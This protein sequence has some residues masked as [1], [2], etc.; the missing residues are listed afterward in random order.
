[1][2]K[3]IAK[4]L[5]KIIGS[6]LNVL[7]HIA[8]KH[9][10]KKALDL[11]ST[12]RNGKIQENQKTFLNTAQQAE[13]HYENIPIKTYHWKGNSK[14][15]LLVHGWESNA[16]RWYKLIETLQGEG[17]NIVALDAPAHGD[18]G[19]K[20]FNALLYSKFINEIAKHHQPDIIIGHSVGGMASAFF[21]KT[22]DYNHLKKLILLGAPSEFTNIFSGYTNMM[23]FNSKLRKSIYKLIINRFGNTPESFSTAKYLKEVSVEGLIIHDK[24]DKIISHSEA[25]MI[26]ESFKNSKLISTVGF[27]HSLHHDSVNQ[28][29]LEFINS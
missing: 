26:H 8:P 27:G 13:L 15:I 20:Q 22:S 11:F 17:Y 1:M 6:S 3:F 5:P 21:Q 25:L 24:K 23:G 4:A 12:P 29:I 28:H 14:T 16:F 7:S 18:S 9:A 10:A 2:K 19:S